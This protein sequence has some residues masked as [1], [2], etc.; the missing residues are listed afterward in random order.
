MDTTGLRFN[1]AGLLKEQAGATREYEIDLPRGG[2]EGLIEE[3]W[4]LDDLRGHVRFL[5][6]PRSIFVR[7]HFDTRLG[8]ECSRCL[9]DAEVTIAFDVEDEFYPAIDI[10]T[11]HPLPVPDDDL[12][13]TIDQNHEL[14]LT[15]SVR[16][17]LLL[18][19]PMQVLCRATCRGLCP[20]CGADLNLAPCRCAD[21]PEDER[22]APLRAL[23]QLQQ[24]GSAG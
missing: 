2:L 10:V 13:F 12:A 22:L 6:T 11:G 4:P 20:Q 17:H 14:D 18:E 24:W 3:A 15:E 16:Q 8:V 9:A 1:V 19:L 21:E 5:R 7:G 23:L